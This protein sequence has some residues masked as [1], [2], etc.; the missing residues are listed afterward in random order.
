[1][2][3]TIQEIG[4]IATVL[5]LRPTLHILKGEPDNRILQCAAAAQAQRIIS[6]DRHLLSLERYVD[7]VIVSL[8][9]FLTELDK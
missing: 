8:A 1:M 7:C 5:R 4:Q 6:G 3:E 2:R 9:D